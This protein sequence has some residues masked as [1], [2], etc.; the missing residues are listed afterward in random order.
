MES[1][2]VLDVEGDGQAPPLS[3]CLHPY[4]FLQSSGQHAM[5]RRIRSGAG[6]IP[7]GWGSPRDNLGSPQDVEVTLGRPSPNCESGGSCGD[8]R[9]FAWHTRAPWWLDILSASFSFQ[10]V[11][12]RCCCSSPWALAH[13]SPPPPPAEGTLCVG[14]THLPPCA[15]PVAGARRRARHPPQHFPCSAVAEHNG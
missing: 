8:F 15:S 12:L 2:L 3:G 9:D 11:L 13:T 7:S 14:T 10:S 5:A 4:S 6:G 1:E